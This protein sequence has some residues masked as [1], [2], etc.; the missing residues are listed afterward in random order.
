MPDYKF[1]KFTTKRTKTKKK[2][3]RNLKSKN[4]FKQKKT[5]I[6]TVKFNCQLTPQRDR[7]R[8]F[9]VFK[10][11]IF[12]VIG[13]LIYGLSMSKNVVKMNI[14]IEK[15]FQKQLNRTAT[16]IAID[17]TGTYR[18]C[19]RFIYRLKPQTKWENKS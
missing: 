5:T 11:R 1:K 15:I 10:N 16:V 9:I 7:E 14:K 3:K 19:T 12:F 4:V 13:V 8:E 6:T 18:G 2:E 17:N